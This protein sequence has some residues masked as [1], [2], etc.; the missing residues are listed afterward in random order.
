VIIIAVGGYLIMKA[1]MN[2][3][4]LI[5]ATLFSAAFLQPIRRLTAFVE[6]YV[7][8]MAGFKRFTEIMRTSEEIKDKPNAV[9]ID[10]AKGDIEYENIGFACIYHSNIGTIVFYI[11]P[12]SKRI[13]EC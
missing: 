11:F 5:T 9:R 6:Q 2:L 10:S 12:K 8:G 7:T 4:D 1:K 3:T 13:L